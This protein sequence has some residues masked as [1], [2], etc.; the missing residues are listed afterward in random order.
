[1][2]HKSVPSECTSTVVFA[3]IEVRVVDGLIRSATEDV[4]AAVPVFTIRKT[5]F[6]FPDAA[7]TVAVLVVVLFLIKTV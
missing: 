1:M 3:L 5:R 7:N 6:V 2:I 4:K